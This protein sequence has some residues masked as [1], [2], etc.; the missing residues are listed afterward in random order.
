MMPPGMLV[1]FFTLLA[2]WVMLF[3]RLPQDAFLVDGDFRPN[4]KT[5]FAFAF[6]PSRPRSIFAAFRKLS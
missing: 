1:A 2:V 4:R 6:S 5:G 3:E